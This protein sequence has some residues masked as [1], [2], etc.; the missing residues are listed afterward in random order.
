MSKTVFF[1]LNVI[2]FVVNHFV[3]EYLPNP[4]LGGWLPLHM[5]LWFAAAPVASLLWGAYYIKFFKTQ[6]DL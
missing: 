4:I 1:I 6:K 3:I 2:Y 5:L